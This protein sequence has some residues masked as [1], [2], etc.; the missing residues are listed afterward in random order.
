MERSPPVK[1]AG[2]VVE[3]GVVLV[4]GLM[5]LG[6]CEV[7]LRLFIADTEAYF[8][9]RPGS[10]TVFLPD[11]AFIQG[12]EGPSRFEVNDLGMR[13]RPLE[14][15]AD[16]Y[17]I[18]TV[19][20]STTELL[21]MDGPRTWPAI[22]EQGLSAG[23]AGVWVGNVGKAGANARDHVLHV[24]HVLD[25]V[26]VIDA[27]LLLVGVNDLTLA[28]AD[29]ETYKTLPPL[30]DSL[31]WAEQAERAFALRPGSISRPL[32]PGEHP[33]FKHT[34]LYQTAARARLQ[35][36]S[37]RAASGITQDQVGEVVGRWRS[38]RAAATEWLTELPDL[39]PALAVYRGYLDQIVDEA[40]GRGVRL[41]LITQP[42]LWKAGMS[43]EEAARL[44]LG[45]D[46]PAFMDRPG[47]R[48][49]TAEALKEGLEAFNDVLLEVCDVRGIECIDLANRIP[50]TTH[51]FYDDVHFTDAGSAE[52]AG[53]VLEH[54][55]SRPP[56][57]DLR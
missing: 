55:R 33:W 34:A 32:Y 9:H 26:P 54:L 17:R 40:E 7:G 57:A 45:G 52:V 13:G 51:Y 10:V 46:T 28:L 18:V 25:Q 11:T 41:V 39:A 53:V 56:F 2:R 35:F 48:Y 15:D 49:F 22:V 27:V 50:R 24:H 38:H 12:V 23:G 3:V 31:A 36:A 42:F 19:G 20:A 29:G 6:L 21:F 47:D 16:E 8:V 44:W 14:P 1:R 30:S 4:S 37:W 5:A 43:P